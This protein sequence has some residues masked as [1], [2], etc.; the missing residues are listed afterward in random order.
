MSCAFHSLCLA[1]L[2]TSLPMRTTFSSLTCGFKRGREDMVTDPS[3][4]EE[5]ECDVL[6][7]YVVNRSGGLVC[8]HTYGGLFTMKQVGV[9]GILYWGRF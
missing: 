5:G 7:T 6:I 9:G 1:L 3:R 4:E 8:S 2:D